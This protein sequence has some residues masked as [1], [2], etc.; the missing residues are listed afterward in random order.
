MRAIALAVVL[1]M[2]FA[3]QALAYDDAVEDFVG[4]GRTSIAFQLA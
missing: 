3:G 2:F 1:M 4:Y